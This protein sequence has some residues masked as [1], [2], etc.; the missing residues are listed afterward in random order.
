M[1]TV[2]CDDCGREFR[3]KHHRKTV[4]RIC[5]R[6]THDERINKDR[7]DSETRTPADE[8][9]SVYNGEDINVIDIN[10]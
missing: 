5:E 6:Q 3:S 2:T 7:F 10:E 9:D 4:C 8:H 1:S